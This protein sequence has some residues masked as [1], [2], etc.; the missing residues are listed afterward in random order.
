MNA[1]HLHETIDIV[2]EQAVPYMERSVLGFEADTAGRGLRL[3]GTWY[4]VGGTGRWPQVVNVWEMTEGWDDWERLCRA[5]NLRREANDDLTDW[6]HEAYE[7]RSGGFD[8]LL[9]PV[10][11][12]RLLADLA[13]DPVKGTMFV[14]ELTQV[15]PGAGAD[16]LAALR[17]GWAPVAAEHGHVLVGAWEVLLG[18][19][20]VCTIWATTLE[21]HVEL[22]KTSRGPGP[23]DDRVAA[24]RTRSREWTTRWREELMVPCPGTPMGPDAWEGTAGR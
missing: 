6:W 22:G 23:L 12:T 18:D 16:Y 20:E 19:T 10:P 4:V 5:T 15:R 14:H 17:E 24:W 8:R 2:G 9:G 3:W 13:R 1:L 11:G 21:D 7:R